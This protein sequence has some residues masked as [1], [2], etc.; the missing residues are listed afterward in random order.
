[1]QI[2]ITFPDNTVTYTT[3]ADNMLTDTII[4]YPILTDIIITDNRG[5]TIADNKYYL[6]T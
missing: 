1:M 3:V 6:S 2:G 4:P 5:T